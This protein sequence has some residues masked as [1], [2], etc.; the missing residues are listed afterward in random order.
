M[1]VAPLREAC[2][3]QLTDHMTTDT[4]FPCYSYADSVSDNK[5]RSAC[6]GFIPPPF[7]QVCPFFDKDTS[8]TGALYPCQ[9]S[10]QCVIA[11][12]ATHEVQCSED[13]SNIK[14]AALL[15]LHVMLNEKC[16]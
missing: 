8:E 16:K 9:V 12:N 15:A 14:R 13:S 10:G 5:L 6:I 7:K 11:C 1:Q 4:V 3:T 2:Q